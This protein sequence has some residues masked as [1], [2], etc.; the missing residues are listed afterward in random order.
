V[1]FSILH[2]TT[3]D[4][5]DGVRE[6]YSVVYLQPRTEPRQIC[7]RYELETNPPS[8]VFRYND[9]FGNEVQH[10]TI[11]PKHSE[12]TIVSRSHVMTLDAEPPQAPVAALRSA[13]ADDPAVEAFYEFTHESPSIVFGPR[14]RSLLTEIE[15]PGEAIGEWYVRA[16]EFVNANFAYDTNAT[17]VFTEVDAAVAGRA[18]SRRKCSR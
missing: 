2:E 14:M 15:M 13:L 6:S 3:Y 12:L 10:F 1:D 16:G 17:T 8:R 5:A 4:Y 7:S 11:I 18:L 9:R